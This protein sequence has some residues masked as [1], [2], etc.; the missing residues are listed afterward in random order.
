MADEKIFESKR[1][2]DQF[3]SDIEKMLEIGLL[4]T[5]HSKYTELI[6]KVESNEFETDD[7]L[8]ADT[9]ASFAYFLFRVSEYDYFF[10]MLIKAQ[11]HGYSRDEIE[12]VLWEAFIE[13]NIS[14]FKDIYESNINFLIA[15]KHIKEAVNFEKL[16][17]WILPTGVPNEYYMYDKEEKLIKEKVVLFK[18]EII[19][20]IQADD[21][22]SD[23]LLIE[24]WDWKSV[25]TY[26]NV[27]KKA[28]RKTYIVLND[29]Q[30]FLSCLQGALLN[31]YLISNVVIFDSFISMEKYF[32][33]KNAYIPRN[34]INLLDNSYTPQN[35]IDNIH[36][37]R[38][39]KENRYG[40]N[41]LLSICIPSYNRGNRALENIVQ[42]L[43]TSYDEEIEIILSNNGTQNM[44]KT[45]YNH[46]R[47]D[48]TDARL[49]Y[50]EFEENQG[51]A[52][53][54]CKVCELARGKFIL[55]LSDE[56]MVNFHV[57]DKIMN[58]LNQSQDSLAILRTSTSIQ[59]RPPSYRLAKQGKDAMLT[60]MLTSNYMS[61]IIFNREMLKQYKGIEY[62]IENQNNSICFW[63]PH[64]YWEL[65][66][67]QFGNVEGTDL[68]FIYEG[69]AEKNE[70][71]EAEI[72]DQINIPYYATIE[73]RLEQHD[74]FLNIFRNL[75]LCI[76]DF[77]LF[78]E[79][80]TKLC[81]KTLT[82]V[83]L[84]INV[85]YK[86]VESAKPLELLDRAYKYCLSNEHS[87]VYLNDKSN[88]QN[89]YEHL[90]T[91]I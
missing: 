29:I 51:F 44:T 2:I 4:E 22:F 6:K 88:I 13:P 48:I 62:I 81:V 73:G 72:G 25:L 49:T 20:V 46:I 16:S 70:T 80:Y 30:K 41:V 71:E 32:S 78:G 79:M 36:N 69:K 87:M 56:D 74:G 40:D 64:M 52:I 66:L 68:M 58:I 35:S 77:T 55:L 43:Q 15:N 10:L 60:Y 5:A 89:Y 19:P 33:G 26:T 11:T 24:D 7:R 53:N 27:I 8:K 90:K 85:F 31:E 45:Y 61:G 23:Y 3:L 83:A 12:K 76:D 21:D 82:L 14:E 54:L 63:Y 9:Y 91:Q 38:I 67:S 42:L 59:S 17:F 34:I 37:L 28:N 75:E 1:H 57:I 50:F 39:V 18:Y 47:D 84:S 86:R 65:L